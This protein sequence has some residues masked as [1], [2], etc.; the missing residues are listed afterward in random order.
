M[1]MF[2]L[3]FM[4]MFMLIFVHA[5]FMFMLMLM[6]MFMLMLMSCVFM[7]PHLFLLLCLLRFAPSTI[8][9]CL[10]VFGDRCRGQLH[11]CVYV[12]AEHVWV[13]RNEC[14]G[15]Q[16]ATTQAAATE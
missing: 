11:R 3:L 2:M 12:Q 5:L 16:S 14:S 15:L 13:P 6:L 1:L 7:Y 8:L 9:P 10:L 4:L